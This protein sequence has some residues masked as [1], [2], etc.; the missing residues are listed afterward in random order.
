V[1]ATIL[2]ETLAGTTFE[3][4][5]DGRAEI[6]RLALPGRHNV[7]NALAAAAATLAVGIDSR[8]VVAGLE[9]EARVPGRL[10]PV[11]A[12]QDF[13]VLVDYAHTDD[14]LRKVLASLRPLVPGR[15]LVVFGCGGDRDRAKRPR[16][17]RVVEEM[18]DVAIVTNDNPRSEDP[19]SI[20]EMILGGMRSRDRARV[21]LDRERA[22]AE[23]IAE[24]RAGDA[25]LIAGKGHEP[26]QIFRD[27]T[28]PFD[29]RSVALAAL[30]SA[31]GRG[32]G[33][34][35]GRR[36]RREPEVTA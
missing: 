21:V 17:G 28:V 10:D 16:M 22:I 2:S 3:M 6:V 36:R 15:I 4:L 35:P 7:Q 9:R 31:P 33:P 14:A 20:A 11:D 12:G 30:A 32:S 24:A 8:A 23:A 34:T 26:G 18:A 1:R 27:R 13:R 25:V 5:H 19:E 29:D